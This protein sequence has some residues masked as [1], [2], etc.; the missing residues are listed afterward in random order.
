[1][2]IFF[3]VDDVA[4][5]NYFDDVYLSSR[6]KMHPRII[7]EAIMTLDDSLVDGEGVAQLLKLLPS[8][9][10]V[11]KFHSLNMEDIPRLGKAGIF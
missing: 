4:V 10:E 3:V 1:M 5:A 7:S 2:I 8:D 11:K 6:L 9:E